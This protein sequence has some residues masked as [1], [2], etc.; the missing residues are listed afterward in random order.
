MDDIGDD[1]EK[2]KLHRFVNVN[3]QVVRMGGIEDQDLVVESD[4]TNSVPTFYPGNNDAAIDYLLLAI[5]NQS[6]SL[7]DLKA[8]HGIG[9]HVHEIGGIRIGNA[10]IIEVN[11]PF[12]VC[13][14]RTGKAYIPLK[15]N[16]L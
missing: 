1:T 14:S 15:T 2:V 6:I 11:S 9:W 7:T 16:L 4:L 3:G 10:Q 8:S 12:E 13:V 5:D